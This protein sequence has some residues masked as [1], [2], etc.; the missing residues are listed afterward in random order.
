M[1]SCAC[2]QFRTDF[3]TVSYLEDSPICSSILQNGREIKT[4]DT[5]RKQPLA[6]SARPLDGVRR[7]GGKCP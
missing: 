2:A 1:G 3:F 4:P 7:E 6:V 5:Q